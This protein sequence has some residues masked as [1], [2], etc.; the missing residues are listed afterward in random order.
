MP[1]KGRDFTGETQIEQDENRGFPDGVKQY[2]VPVFA[3]KLT[4]SQG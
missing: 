3:V 4:P 1:K 2:F